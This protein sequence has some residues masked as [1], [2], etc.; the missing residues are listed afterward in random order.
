MSRNE[1]MARF[2]DP[3]DPPVFCHCEFCQEEI[4]KGTEAVRYEGDY[5]CEIGCLV[6][7]LDIEFVDV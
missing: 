2:K 4:Y 3:E 6:Q 1:T 5:F 7:N